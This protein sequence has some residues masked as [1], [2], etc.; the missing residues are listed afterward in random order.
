MT[1]ARSGCHGRD[2]ARLILER[3]PELRNERGQARRVPLYLF[4]RDESIRWL[5]SG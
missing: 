4:A 5:R 3:D 1:S 2:D